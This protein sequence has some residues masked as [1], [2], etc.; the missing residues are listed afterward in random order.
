[1]RGVEREVREVVLEPRPVRHPPAEPGPRH[2][3]QGGQDPGEE[4]HG[5]RQAGAPTSAFAAT[6]ARRSTSGTAA[7]A[8]IP[9]LMRNFAKP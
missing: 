6:W 3:G 4:P 1:M 7:P 5:R 8:N 2:A 9:V